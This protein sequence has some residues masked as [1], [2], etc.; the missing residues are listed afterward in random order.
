MSGGALSFST[1]LDVVS[2]HSIAKSLQRVRQPMM[3]YAKWL[4][5]MFVKSW[6]ESA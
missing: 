6:K 1:A 5:D 2:T 4:D 3:Q